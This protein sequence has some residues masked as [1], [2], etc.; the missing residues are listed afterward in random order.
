MGKYVEAF[1]FEKEALAK[2]RAIGE[3]TNLVRALADIGG[4]EQVQGRYEEAL[5]YFDEGLRLARQVDNKGSAIALQ[6]NTAQVHEDQ[7]DYGAALQLLADAEKAARDARESSYLASVL[8]YLGSA[9]RRAGDLAGSAAALTEAI[10]LCREQ[11]NDALLAEALV[12]DGER[13]L[14]QE[15]RGAVVALKDAV[16]AAGRAGDYRVQRMARLGLARAEGSPRDLEAVLKDART[17]GLAPLV[18]PALVSLAAM[19]LQAGRLD[20]AA[21]RAREAAGEAAK[22]KERDWMMQARRIEG[23][24]LLRQGKTEP[25]A[26]AFRQALAPFEEMRAGLA[27]PSLA[28]FLARPETA[29]LG[30]DAG[31]ALASVPADH[32]RLLALL[33]P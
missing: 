33:R 9:R 10:R 8:T 16:A 29:A 20:Q 28:A 26:A 18:A 30:R 25:A 23:S 31:A 2:A 21:A 15:D 13:R 27:G 6:I 7:G 11:N 12:Y 1:F 4:L 14:A 24:A 22:L 32:D 5:K 3:Q 17:S 19:D